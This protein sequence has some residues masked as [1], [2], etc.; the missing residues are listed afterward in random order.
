[1][2]LLRLLE[3][4][5]IIYLSSIHLY[6]R[7]N[8]EHLLENEKIEYNYQNSKKISNNFSKLYNFNGDQKIDYIFFSLC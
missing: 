4:K 1:M 5:R 3:I 8:V 6:M 7:T 2:Q